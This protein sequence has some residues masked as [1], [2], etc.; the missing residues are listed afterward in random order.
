MDTSDRYTAVKKPV[1]SFDSEPG[2]TVF[3]E[4]NDGVNPV[5]DLNNDTYT[6]LG[7]LENS[8]FLEQVFDTDE[9]GNNTISFQV[10]D[11]FGQVISST[12]LQSRGLSF[13]FQYSNNGTSFEDADVSHYNDGV[14]IASLADGVV[15][16]PELDGVT[17]I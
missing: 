13:K 8:Y 4:K 14:L 16:A 3:I 17:H 5:S 12:L 11:I 2:L 15:G 1:I 10:N 9:D 6:V 7:G